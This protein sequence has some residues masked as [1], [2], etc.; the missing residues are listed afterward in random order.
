MLSHSDAQGF[1]ASQEEPGVERTHNAPEFAHVIKFQSLNVL[2]IP[3]NGNPG[4]HIAV[5]AD[6]F[7]RRV[8]H[9]INPHFQGTLKVGGGECIIYNDFYTSFFGKG[10]DFFNIN[11][12]K[13]GIAGSFKV[14]NFCVF[15]NGIFQGFPYRTDRGSGR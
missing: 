10:G 4:H 3:G 13:I 2:I 6:V 7:C 1:E 11:N 9:H 5:T 14:D 15:I 8:N 12:G